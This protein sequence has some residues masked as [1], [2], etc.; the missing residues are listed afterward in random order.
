MSTPSLADRFF[1]EAMSPAFREDPYPHY[2]RFRGPAQQRRGTAEA[3]VVGIGVLAEGGRHRFDEEPVGQAGR[4]H[5]NLA[6]AIRYDTVSSCN[7]LESM[8][9]QECAPVLPATRHGKSCSR[10][11]PR[12]SRSTASARPASK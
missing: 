10:Q 4:A 11:P 5:G 3:L 1:V 7:V 9:C 12:C 8:S 2:E 6:S